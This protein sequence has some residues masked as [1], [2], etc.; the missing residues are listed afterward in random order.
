MGKIIQ[1]RY[2]VGIL[3]LL[4]RVLALAMDQKFAKK[5]YQNSAVMRPWSGFRSVTMKAFDPIGAVQTAL[6]SRC[7]FHFNGEK[8]HLGSTHLAK[9]CEFPRIGGECYDP[10][11]AVMQQHIKFNP[12]NDS[13][14]NISKSVNS[15][16]YLLE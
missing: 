10:Q 7:W 15:L 14:S 11:R 12:K 16:L 6:Y 13:R 5:Y 9:Y 8:P 2:A 3:E 4:R 1:Q